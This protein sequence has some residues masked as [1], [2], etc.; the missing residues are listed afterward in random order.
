MIDFKKLWV[1]V[2]SG[3]GVLIAIVAISGVKQGWFAPSVVYR[4]KFANG[5]GVFVGTPVSISGLKAGSV[6]QVELG[7][8]NQVA[9]EIKVQ[10]KFSEFIREDSKATL[11]RPFIIG[12]RAISITPGSKE[13]A[14]VQPGSFIVG[15]ESLELTDLLSGGRLSPYFQTFSKLLDQVRLVIEGDGTA[16]SKN[17]LDVYRQAYKTLKALEEVLTEV[18]II[19]KDFLFGKDTQKLISE[20]AG[21]SDELSGL[22]VEGQKAVPNLNQLSED[23]VKMMPQITR[24]LEETT[25]TLQALQRSF[26]LRGATKEV[27]EEMSEKEEKRKRSLATEGSE[28]D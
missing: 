17:L 21:S 6:K 3:L 10:S 16:D 5:D 24:T 1:F 12:E 2:G 25:V 28:A 20:L 8:D 4:A 18:R 15:E 23:V 27:R 7:A 22:L 26:L 19:R 14:I 11:G 13:K 9:V